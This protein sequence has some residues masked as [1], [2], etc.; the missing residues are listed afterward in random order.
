MK[1]RKTIKE[2]L[3]EVMKIYRSAQQFMIETG[4]PTQWGTFYPDE[5]MVIRDIE[6][7]FS[8][9]CIRDGE[10][11]AV[12]YF[13][14]NADEADY[15]K[16]DGAWLNDEP[17]GVVH[18]IASKAGSHAGGFCIDW[19]VS[20][21]KNLRIDTHDDNLPMQRLLKRLGF[22][23]CGRIELEHYGARIAYQKCV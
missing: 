4:N 5:E 7:G 10:I 11:V 1:I 13:D 18:R 19:C 2:D 22:T 16:I 14:G 12:F 15:R 8:H 17:Y 20:E 23:F 9:V 3:A 21:C 6:N